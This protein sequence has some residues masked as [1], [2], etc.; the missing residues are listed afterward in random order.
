V[1]ANADLRGEH[2]RR[3]WWGRAPHVGRRAFRYRPLEEGLLHGSSS[4]PAVLVKDAHGAGSCTGRPRA[5]Q[6]GQIVGRFSELL[7]PE[8]SA[9]RFTDLRS[10][11][12]LWPGQGSS[13]GQACEHDGQ[14]FSV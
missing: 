6:G 1:A 10:L 14:Y 5:A 2:Y 13:R 3:Q 9:E 11:G 7:A 12:R 4:H 8:R